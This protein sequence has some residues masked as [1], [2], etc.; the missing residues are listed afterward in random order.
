MN[1]KKYLS[2]SIYNRYFDYDTANGDLLWK[3]DIG[4]KIKKGDIAGC[5]E[6][7]RY[8]RVA[9]NGQRYFVHR[10]IW[11][12]HNGEIP[13]N[14]E[15]DHIDRNGL[16]NKLENL[17]LVTRRENILNSN[18]VLSVSPF[19]KFGGVGYRKDRKRWYARIQIDK[20]PIF[21]GSFKWRGEAIVALQKYIQENEIK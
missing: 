19:N 9:I 3:I 1:F 16:N 11:I 4:R 13:K 17:R 5:I 10:I 12:M 20:K 2:K 21:I 14:Y 8:K 7:N 6:Q 18:I 15:I